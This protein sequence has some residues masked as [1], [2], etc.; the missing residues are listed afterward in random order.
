V[1]EQVAAA[2]ARFPN[3]VAV[4]LPRPHPDENKLF[5]REVADVHRG[6]F[7]ERADEYGANIRWKLELCVEVTDGEVA[8]AV[9]LRERYRAECAE[10]LAEIDLLVTP[11]MLFVA[12]PAD[13]DERELRGRGIRLTY[14]FNCLGWPALAL[15]CGAAEDGL[16]AS[17]QLVGKPGDDARVLAA[18]ALL[19]SLI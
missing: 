7:P 1:R 2:A 15:P 14:P 3:R 18:G 5:M 13:A 4:E 17:V 16:P 8:R 12:P 11:T 19:A 10:L 9:E 6:L